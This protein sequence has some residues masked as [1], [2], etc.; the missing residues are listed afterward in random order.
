MGRDEELAPLGEDR[1][2]EQRVASAVE[3]IAEDDLAG[4][5]KEGS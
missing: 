2:A 4:E 3:V 5:L 1:R